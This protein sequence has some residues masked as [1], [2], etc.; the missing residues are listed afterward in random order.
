MRVPSLP[1]G[2]IFR[3]ADL[4]DGGWLMLIL[5]GHVGEP[6][7]WANTLPAYA[8]AAGGSLFLT[9]KDGSGGGVAAVAGWRPFRRNFGGSPAFRLAAH[10]ATLAGSVYYSILS[11][12]LLCE[13]L[14]PDS[15]DHHIKLRSSRRILTLTSIAYFCDFLVFL[16]NSI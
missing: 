16:V 2:S 7:S 9:E 4:G 14:A 5:S 15:P 1:A 11:N 3:R 12:T 6:V 8:A 10:N 13:N